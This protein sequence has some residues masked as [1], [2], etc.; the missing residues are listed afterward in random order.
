MIRKPVGGVG[1]PVYMVSNQ[2]FRAILASTYSEAI[3][4]SMIC[5]EICEMEVISYFSS[6]NHH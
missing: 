3:W 1:D 5:D 4:S 2:L 6:N